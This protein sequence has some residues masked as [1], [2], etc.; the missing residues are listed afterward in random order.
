MVTINLLACYVCTHICWNIRHSFVGSWVQFTKKVITTFITSESRQKLLSSPMLR[1]LFFALFC[2]KIGTYVLWDVIFGLDSIFLDFTHF[3]IF[4][5]I[6]TSIRHFPTMIV[7][8]N[9]ITRKVIRSPKKSV[10]W[11]RTNSNHAQLA[12]EKWRKLPSW[13]L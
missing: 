1:S 9:N 11:H 7:F 3:W 12:V 2:V 6:S 10:A 13:Y 5:D 8:E 4:F